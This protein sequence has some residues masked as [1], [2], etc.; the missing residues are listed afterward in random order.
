M[1]EDNVEARGSEPLS[2]VVTSLF[3]PASV[4]P[5]TPAVP[6]AT[7][8]SRMILVS[9]C[10]MIVSLTKGDI[11]VDLRGEAHLER[12][13]RGSIARRRG[14]DTEALAVDAIRTSNVQKHTMC[15]S[16]ACKREGE[17]ARGDSC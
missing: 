4:R 14:D 7:S 17:Q 6:F 2:C 13:P 1:N 3:P 9:C 16:A 12:V 10:Y 8:L 5:H 11:K 15:V